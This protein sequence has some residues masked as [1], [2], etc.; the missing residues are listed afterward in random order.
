MIDSQE[1][2][3]L[4]AKLSQL[5]LARKWTVTAAESC[6]G[7][8]V[9]YAF[10]ALPGCSDWFQAGF[11]TYSNAVKTDQLSVSEKTLEKY[12]AVS[13]EVV[14][15]MAEGALVKA[16]ANVA[17]AISGV[18]GPDGGTEFKPVGTV[19]ISW[20]LKEGEI[21]TKEF[22]FTGDRREVRQQAIT[23]ALLGLIRSISKI[24][25]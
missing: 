11:V 22:R 21:L 12:G 9:A 23:E 7:G 5:L 24:P 13:E 17:V 18:A 25:V 6:T 8:G 19:W 1:T 16:R 2:L 4:V 20:A 10:T 3:F 14:M 15:Q